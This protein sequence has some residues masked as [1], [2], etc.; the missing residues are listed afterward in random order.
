M[1]QAQ[2]V[3]M[4]RR[5]SQLPESTEKDRK[6]K[7]YKRSTSHEALQELVID[8]YADMAAAQQ[9]T[10]QGPA[11][12]PSKKRARPQPPPCPT[13][14]KPPALQPPSRAWKSPSRL[15][16]SSSW[17]SI[18]PFEDN[19]AARRRMLFA[20]SLQRWQ[21][22]VPSSLASAALSNDTVA[23]WGQARILHF[24]WSHYEQIFAR[25]VRMPSE[26][27][28]FDV[29]CAGP[30]AK[31]AQENAEWAGVESGFFC[32][33]AGYCDG[34][35][36]DPPELQHLRREDMPALL[37][38]CCKRWARQPIARDKQDGHFTVLHPT[39]KSTMLSEAWASGV[40]DVTWKC[41]A[42]FAHNKR[43][44]YDHLAAIHHG[45]K[46]SDRF[47]SQRNQQNK[48]IRRTQVDYSAEAVE[49]KRSDRLWAVVSSA[50]EQR[51]NPRVAGWS[52]DPIRHWNVDPRLCSDDV[53]E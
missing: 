37:R 14:P 13:H 26:I 41:W 24:S 27:S 20:S 48:R 16:S 22:T 10:L 40:A 32:D 52:I 1:E 25:G 44:T 47:V 31:L 4:E 45:H 34:L 8:G 18:R 38:L 51:V 49:R 36:P 23:L 46:F 21:K 30:A 35:V 9:K 39:L 50:Q 43:T 7:E 2:N 33:C 11:G 3:F 6:Y 17:K 12:A 53:P 19:A 15:V 42:C 28:C 29:R 5:F